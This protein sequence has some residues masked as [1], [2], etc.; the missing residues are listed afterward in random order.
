MLLSTK[1][2]GK[3]LL[4]YF[5]ACMSILNAENTIDRII[6]FWQTEDLLRAYQ[7]DIE[8]LT[9]KQ[10]VQTDSKTDEARSFL[11]ELKE[12]MEKEDVLEKGHTRHS[13]LL[14]EEKETMHL[15]LLKSNSV[16]KET[17][18]KVQHAVGAYNKQQ[19]I[20]LGAVAVLFE[21]LYAYY[22]KKLS[23]DE[24]SELVAQMANTAA[25]CINILYS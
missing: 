16:Y 24:E 7:F 1:N 22:L 17:F 13:M 10:F 2:H 18:E 12:A 8:K 5:R 6:G 23:G 4:G 25:E 3:R 21:L 20:N 19:N 9:Q 15:E 11:V 14:I